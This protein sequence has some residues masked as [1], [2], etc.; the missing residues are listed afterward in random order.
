MSNE[1][2][3]P[4]CHASLNNPAL[5]M[6]RR[7]VRL[8]DDPPPDPAE[9]ADLKRIAWEESRQVVRDAEG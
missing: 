8:K 2:R 7:L 3:C 6:L 9:R 5:A 4:A 1:Q